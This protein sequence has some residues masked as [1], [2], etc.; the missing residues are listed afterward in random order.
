MSIFYSCSSYKYVSRGHFIE[1]VD[2]YFNL[3][4]ERNIWVYMD[5][6]PKD[7]GVYGVRTTSFY[8][9][10]KT[11]LDFIG[12]KGRNVRTYFSAVPETTPRYHLIVLAHKNNKFDYSDYERVEEEK[13]EGY[14]YYKDFD[15][16]FRAIRHVVIPYADNKILSMV[17]Y[18]D[19]DLNTNGSF[20][21]LHY[22]ASINAKELQQATPFTQSWQV[23]DCDQRGQL[24]AHNLTFNKALVK[25]HKT[26][27]AKLYAIYK[28]EEGI[29]YAKILT[30]DSRESINLKLCP[31]KYKLVYYTT[32]GKRLEQEEFVIK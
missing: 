20:P 16:D 6:V 22:L 27:Y 13:S 25:K 18:I 8:P 4:N 26:I 19:K 11:I 5:F 7:E 24:E 28:S 21:K 17:Y 14:Y 30:K 23:F 3:K 31:N 10:D 2:Q 29:H 9:N 12:L 1:G 15:K 32:Q